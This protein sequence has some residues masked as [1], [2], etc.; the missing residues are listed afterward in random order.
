MV[1]SSNILSLIK[2]FHEN[3]IGKPA[4]PPFWSLGFHQSRWGYDSVDTLN[5]ILS[6]YEGLGLP[7]D[8]IWSDIDYMMDFQ[9]FTVDTDNFPLDAMRKITEKYRYVPIVDAGVSRDS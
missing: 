9:D 4:I 8:T 1:S 5:D 2:S 6:Q 3:C 7:L